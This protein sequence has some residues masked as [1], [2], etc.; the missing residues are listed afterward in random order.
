[1]IT[2]PRST[3]ISRRL[4]ALVFWSKAAVAPPKPGEK[5]F[6]MAEAQKG[7]RRDILVAATFDKLVLDN[8][9]VPFNTYQTSDLSSWFDGGAPASHSGWQKL[10]DALGTKIG[11]PGLPALALTL[12]NGSERAKRDFLRSFPAEILPKDLPM[13]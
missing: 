7:W 13:R 10:L 12:E 5:N 11:R 4:A 9:P 8:L 6:L 2:W 3:T 1:M